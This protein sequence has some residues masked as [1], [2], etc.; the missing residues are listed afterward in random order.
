M[1]CWD[2]LCGPAL[3]ETP[4]SGSKRQHH[5]GCRFGNGSIR[6]G[7]RAAAGGLAEVSTPDIIV[8][9]VDLIVGV[10]VGGESDAGLAKSLAPHDVVGRVDDAISVVIAGK[11]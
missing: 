11:N 8:A 9:L 7:T 3:T 2:F 10:A 6:I 5:H 1:S 4:A